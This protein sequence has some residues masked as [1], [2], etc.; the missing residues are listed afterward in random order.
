MPFRN[1]ATGMPPGIVQLQQSDIEPERFLLLTPV[2]YVRAQAPA[3]FQ[4]TPAALG[5]TDLASIPWP[6]RWFVSPYGEHTL[7]ALLHDC[8]V[9]DC[10]AAGGGPSI[11]RQEA[12]DLFLSSMGEQD[13]PFVRRHVMWSAVTFV[14][15]IR[16]SGVL[17]AL[18]VVIWMFASLTGTAL[19]AL[20]LATWN[21]PVVVAAAL[22]PFPFSL[23]WLEKWLAG[24]VLAFAVLILV[25]AALVVYAAFTVYWAIEFLAYYA[26]LGPKPPPY[27]AF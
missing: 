5:L 19:F 21:L 6:V 9:E 3:T 13:V 22:A 18:L 14:T 10:L 26:G 25:P 20:G 4:V 24:L 17:P 16:H 2:E 27:T 11:T 23:L 7:P 8:T 1:P 15:R 12:D